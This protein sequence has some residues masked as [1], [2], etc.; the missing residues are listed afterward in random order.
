VRRSG[1]S[2]SSNAERRGASAGA[3]LAR[4]GTGEPSPEGPE[5]EAR[6]PP[7]PLAVDGLGAPVS[8]DS[9]RPGSGEGRRPS[10]KRRRADRR[11]RASGPRRSGDLNCFTRVPAARCRAASRASAASRPRK[12]AVDHRSRRASGRRAAG[13]AGRAW[14]AG[15]WI[16]QAETSPRATTMSRGDRRATCPDGAVLASASVRWRGRSRHQL[17]DESRRSRR[18]RPPLGRAR[19]RRLDRRRGPRD[20]EDREDR[21]Q[22]A[23]GNQVVERDDRRAHLVAPVVRAVCHGLAAACRRPDR[24]W[25]ARRRSTR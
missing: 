6:S 5:P 16:C 12:A 3:R 4:H 23:I 22:P 25:R 11:L 18:R 2:R 21:R 19:S 7:P 1:A 24:S 15:L 9:L 20:H 17:V 10:A 13:P 8:T 14:R